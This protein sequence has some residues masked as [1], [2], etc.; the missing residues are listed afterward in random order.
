[1]LLAAPSIVAAMSSPSRAAE[2]TVA[3]CLSASDRATA[4]KSEG[5]YRAARKSF[6]TCVAD[7]CPS[8]V[9]RDCV[10]SLTELD[11]LQPSFVFDVR[12]ERGA[13]MSEVRVSMDGEPLVEKLDGKPVN[14]DVG[15]HV[16][17]FAAGPRYKEQRVQVIARTTEKNRILAV[18]LEPVAAASADPKPIAP[19]HGEPVP[20][21][22]I[23]LA[24]VGVVALGAFAYLGLSARSDLR[25]LESD[26]CA[27][28]KTCSKSDVDSVRTRFAIADVALG[29]GVVSFVA[30][31]WLWFSRDRTQTTARMPLE[32]LPT[33]RGVS[34]QLQRS[35]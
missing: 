22:P 15:P 7:S 20:V 21:F 18:K 1:V 34:V 23:M 17:T 30:A 25:A 10:T 26:P 4:L 5:R 32:V 6:L 28:S 16:F 2:P 12:D 29:V 31:A 9:R 13:D 8:V 19:T 24:G 27:T 14:V 3:E 11:Q 35:F 33:S